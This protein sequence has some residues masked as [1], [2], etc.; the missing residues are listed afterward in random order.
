MV[1]RF[2]EYEMRIEGLNQNAILCD[3]VA[4]CQRKQA[5]EGRIFELEKAAAIL[6]K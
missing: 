3:T 1:D 2:A 6:D 4:F 5:L